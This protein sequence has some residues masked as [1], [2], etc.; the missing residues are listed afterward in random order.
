MFGG[1]ALLVGTE[2]HGVRDNRVLGAA[3]F[4]TAGIMWGAYT[5]LLHH[6]QFPV[7]EGTS[8]IASFGAIF[9]LIVLAP[10]AWPSLAATDLTMVLTQIVMQKGG[11]RSL[12]RHRSCRRAATPQC[13]NSSLTAN[14][15][16]C[17]GFGDSMD[18]I[19]ITTRAS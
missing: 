3:L 12:Q 9:A 4:V 15:H 11:G 14:A 17:S 18:G 16:A 7:L 2:T 1:L 6:W 13:A 19:G 5:V 8:A 10:A